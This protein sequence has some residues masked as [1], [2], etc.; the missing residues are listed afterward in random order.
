MAATTAPA[1]PAALNKTAVSAWKKSK[2]LR[3]VLLWAFA[4]HGYTALAADFTQ[5]RAPF[6]LT[7]AERWWANVQHWWT[8]LSGNAKNVHVKVGGG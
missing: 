3:T 5:L 8:L 6:I 1:K 2:P 4:I 7:D